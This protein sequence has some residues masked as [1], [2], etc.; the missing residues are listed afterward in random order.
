MLLDGSVVDV[1]II[2]IHPS[3]LKIKAH[4]GGLSLLFLHHPGSTKQTNE[5]A[6]SPL[7]LSLFLSP[8]G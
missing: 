2:A 6:H 1:S 7:S 5:L 4:A 3:R 8:P